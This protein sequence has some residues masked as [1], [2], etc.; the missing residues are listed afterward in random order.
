V[1]PVTPAGAGP[2][3]ADGGPVRPEGADDVDTPGGPLPGEEAVEDRPA[4]ALA[5]RVL[6]VAPFALLA[7]F[8][9]I[10]WWVTR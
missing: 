5:R 1:E 10:E 4:P 2:G 8:F 3:G 9:L 6:A 7:L